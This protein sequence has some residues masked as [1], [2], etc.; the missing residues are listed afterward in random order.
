M[1]KR[2]ICQRKQLMN[3]RFEASQLHFEVSHFQCISSQTLKHNIPG[4]G[5]V[6]L[7]AL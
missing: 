4:K 2:Q 5:V 6:N 7:W 3:N 1:R